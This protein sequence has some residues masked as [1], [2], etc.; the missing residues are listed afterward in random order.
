MLESLDSFGGSLF[1]SHPGRCILSVIAAK[2]I[3]TGPCPRRRAEPL[4]RAGA[5]GPV[6]VDPPSTEDA[7][8]LA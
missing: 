8:D 6:A 2:L 4:D 7:S 5:A 3:P 1:V